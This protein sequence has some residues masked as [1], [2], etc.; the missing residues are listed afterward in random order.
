VSVLVTRPEP[1]NA[2]T[3]DALRQRGYDVLLAPILQFEA[4]PIRHDDDVKYGGV[5][6]TSSNALRAVRSHPL[7]GQL[8][9]LPL[10]A[11]GNRTAD[12]ARN[13][14]FANV[15][16]ADG[17]VTALRKLVTDTIPRRQRR[18]PL[19]YLSGSDI[20]ADIVSGLANDGITAT[21]LTV[22]RMIPVNDLPD[23]VRTALAG[24]AIKAVLHYSPRSAA[25]FV[26][27]IRG[28]A[29]EIAGLAVLQICISEAVA[30]VLREAGATR[31]V[32][33]ENRREAAML[34]ALQRSLP[35]Q[36]QRG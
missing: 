17:D 13:I 18:T 34:D 33:A 27:A 9:E 30:R 10:F 14:G 25:A 3:A 19:L 20:A 1:D 16:S 4:L 24:D 11:V 23:Q 12:A 5:I 8:I 29:L 6:V 36:N 7:S 22:Y 26:A 2:T 28:A 15:L 21:P 32:V 35:Q 31:L